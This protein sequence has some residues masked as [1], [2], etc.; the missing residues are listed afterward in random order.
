M[1]VSKDGRLFINYGPVRKGD[2]VINFDILSGDMLFVDRFTYNFKKPK[3]GDSIV[4]LTKY[5]DGMTAM[6]NGVPDD[7]Y[8][9]KRLVGSAATS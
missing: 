6:N 1:I 9:I 5:C 4:F 8:Y 2:R 3:I 7:K